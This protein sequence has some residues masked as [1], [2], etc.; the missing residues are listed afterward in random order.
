MTN[1]G[2]RIASWL[3]VAAAIAAFACSGDAG[4]AGPQGPA[5]PPGPG[6]SQGPSGTANVIYSDWLSFQQGQRDTVV[7]GSNMKVNHIPAPMLTQDIMD[8]GAI[9]VFMRFSTII[10]PLPFT[11][12][13]GAG[14][15]PEKTSTV[16]FLP[17]PG[18]LYITRYTHDN[19]ASIGY[20][21]LQFRYVLIPGG[22]SANASL[23]GVNL[24]DYGAV[25]AALRLV[26]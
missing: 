22:L 17:R 8:R 7:D 14:T 12:D 10:W 3:A 11:S 24:H 13:A 26:D 5:G 4:P 21:S 20:G 9:L 1:T 23:E 18:T 19:S 25:S 15:G 2:G 16:S 6:G